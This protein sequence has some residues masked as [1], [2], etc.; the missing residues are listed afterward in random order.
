MVHHTA[1]RNT[2]APLNTPSHTTPHHL[3]QAHPRKYQ[4]TC[5]IWYCQYQ[6]C[7]Y[8]SYPK[9]RLVTAACRRNLLW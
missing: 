7:R 6:V 2:T 5:H 1:L 8:F 9:T 4:E 3:I